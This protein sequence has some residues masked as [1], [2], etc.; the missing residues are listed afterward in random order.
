[1]QKI[2]LSVPGFVLCFALATSVH[3]ADRHIRVAEYRDK[4]Y[5]AWADRLWARLTASTL[6]VRRAM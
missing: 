3:A 1:M 4:V 5:G 2:F 6:K